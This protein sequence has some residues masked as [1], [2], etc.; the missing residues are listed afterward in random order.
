MLVDRFDKKMLAIDVLTAAIKYIR[1]FVLQEME[2]RGIKQLNEHEINWVITVPA[3]WSNAAKQFMRQA[4]Q[5]V[6]IL[7]MT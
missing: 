2:K 7:L 5:L 1:E 3:I 6:G 4:A